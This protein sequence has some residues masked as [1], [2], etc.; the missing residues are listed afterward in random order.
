MRVA[1]D[2]IGSALARR[3]AAEDTRLTESRFR[4]LVQN[5][6]DALIV[7]DE[8]AVI[9]HMPL[10]TRLFGYTPEQLFGMN[11]LELVHPDDLDFAATEMIRAVTEPDYVGHQRDADP[12]RRR[13]LGADRADGVEPLRRPRDQRRRHERPRPHRAR[14]VRRRA[15]HQRGA[16]PHADREPPGRRVPLPGARRRTRTSSSPT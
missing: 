16:P 6:G 7:I 10:G 3:D 8:N 11:T 14:R 4:A 2:V 1:A 9:S 13:P 15:A 5:S 12:P